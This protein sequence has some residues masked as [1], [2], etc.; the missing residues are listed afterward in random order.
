MQREILELRRL[1]AQ[2]LRPNSPRGDFS[3]VPK[4]AE[5][6]SPVPMSSI[7]PYRAPHEPRLQPI[8]PA[9]QDVAEANTYVPTRSDVMFGAQSIGNVSL[10]GDRVAHLFSLYALPLYLCSANTN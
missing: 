6:S 8:S 2:S 10:S 9:P 3:P 7:E 1:H 5:F 4:Q